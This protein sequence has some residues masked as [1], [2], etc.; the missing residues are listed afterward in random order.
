LQLKKLF[1]KECGSGNT[2]VQAFRA[3]M[4]NLGQWPPVLRSFA[5][6]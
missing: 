6:V 2:D 3:G 1:F 4:G 5:L